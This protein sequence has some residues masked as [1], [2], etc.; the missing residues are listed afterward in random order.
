MKVSGQLHSL[1]TLSPQKYT[2]TLWVEGWVGPRANLDTVIKR[3]IIP[4]LPL[5]EIKP[6]SAV[7][8]VT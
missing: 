5:P 7:W 4:S 3:K 1:A 6:W 2:T 8:T